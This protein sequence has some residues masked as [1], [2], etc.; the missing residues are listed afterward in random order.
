MT[1]LNSSTQTSMMRSVIFSTGE[2]YTVVNQMRFVTVQCVVGSC[3][4]VSITRRF[5]PT[6]R[7]SIHRMLKLLTEESVTG[8][9]SIRQL[10]AEPLL[11]F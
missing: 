5:V 7:W 10:P 2:K 8:E 9:Y 3:T 4:V 6:E 1:D 11:N